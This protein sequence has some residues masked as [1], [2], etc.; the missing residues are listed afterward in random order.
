MSKVIFD[1]SMSL[2]G[3][4]T[5]PN[6]RPE[7]PNG[8]GGERLIE[9]AFAGDD[10]DRRILE[11]GVAGLGAVIAGR[12][13]YDLSLP[14]WGPGGPAGEAR[15]PVFVL[16]HGTPETV[17]EGGVYTFVD[18]V[19]RA[20]EQARAAAGEKYVCVMG[21]AETGRQFLH[22]GLVDELSIHLVPIELGGGTRL[23]DAA[24]QT[25]AATHLRFALR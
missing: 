24:V 11:D 25:E 13:T 18:G 16:S 19:E 21:G 12:R 1:I 2:D 9:W 20:L 5:G 23:F 22:A 6:P 7:S 10:R 4:V 14:F 3:F 8:D 17:P 15:V